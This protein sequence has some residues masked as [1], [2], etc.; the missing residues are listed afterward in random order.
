MPADSAQSQSGPE[1][2]P[3][4]GET[5]SSAPNRP[6]DL[7]CY[8]CGQP[9]H[10][11]GQCTAMK[12]LFDKNLITPAGLNYQVRDNMGAIIPRIR[13]GQ[14]YEAVVRSRLKRGL[15][16]PPIVKQPEVPPPA[17]NLVQPSSDSD[18]IELTSSDWEDDGFDD[19]ED[20]YNGDADD[21]QLTDSD[22][23]S[24]SDQSSKCNYVLNSKSKLV[25]QQQRAQK[26]LAKIQQ[27]SSS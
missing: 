26:T 15:L 13:D 27:G 6:S 22:D 11:Y 8:V 21:L 1:K 3:Q 18:Q 10:G 25:S 12:D 4:Q 9:G 14:P 23:D 20:V 19:I 2:G 24:S 17:V 5:Q 7:V 16:P